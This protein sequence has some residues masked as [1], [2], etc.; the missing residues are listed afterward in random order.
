[1][2]LRNIS[3]KVMWN[4]SGGNQAIEMQ[5]SFLAIKLGVSKRRMKVAFKKRKAEEIAAKA[6]FNSNALLSHQMKITRVVG[7]FKAAY[8]QRCMFVEGEK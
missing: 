2:N 8:E 5:C 7:D 6:S 1:M 3:R 4:Y